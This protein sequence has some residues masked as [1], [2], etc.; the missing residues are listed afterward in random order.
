[1]FPRIQMRFPNAAIQTPTQTQTK[2]DMGENVKG[3]V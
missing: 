1:M 2:W 3:K